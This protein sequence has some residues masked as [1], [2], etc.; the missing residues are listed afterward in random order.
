MGQARIGQET[1][2]ARSIIFLDEDATWQDA[3]RSFQHTH[4]PVENEVRKYRKWGRPFFPIR[5]LNLLP[6]SHMFGQAMATFIPPMLPGTTIFLRGYNPDEIVRQMGSIR[7]WGGRFIV[8]IPE[9][10][11]IE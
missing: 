6:L 9:V 4:V 1:A 2:C 8:P 5:F 7:T 10:R 3:E 11:I